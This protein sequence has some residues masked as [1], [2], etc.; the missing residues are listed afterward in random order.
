MLATLGHEE[1]LL[2]QLN[3]VTSRQEIIAARLKTLSVLTNVEAA[4]L[5]DAG[6]AFH[7]L[8][9]EL[10]AFSRSVSTQ[11]LQLAAHTDAHKAT[12]R[13]IR[14]ELTNDLPKL[15]GEVERIDQDIEVVLRTIDS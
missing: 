2:G 13:K 6:G 5:S 11:T 12:I 3:R 9:Q 4:H 1:T 7:L 15:Q 14:L 10:S 8:A